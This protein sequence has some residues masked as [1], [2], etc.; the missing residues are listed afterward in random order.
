[1]IYT[2]AR[3]GSRMDELTF[4]TFDICTAAVNGTITFVILQSPEQLRKMVG[5]VV[6]VCVAFGLTVSEAKAKIMCLRTK[7]MPESTATFGV[8]AAG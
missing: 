4:S 1:M 7:G 5:G 3:A 8:E 2:A 6:V